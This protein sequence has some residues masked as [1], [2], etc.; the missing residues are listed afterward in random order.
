VRRH[1]EAAEATRIPGVR[2]NVIQRYRLKIIYRV[3]E[4]ENI[5]EII[6]IRHTSFRP[7]WPSES[8]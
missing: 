6:H 1:P 7:W 3:V 2:A 5:V 4:T 8:D